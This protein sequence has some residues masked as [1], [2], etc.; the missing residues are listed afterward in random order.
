[1]SAAPVRTR[2]PALVGALI[3]VAVLL[4][5]LQ[6]ATDPACCR[7]RSWDDPDRIA[8]SVKI[9]D[10]AIVIHT[11]SKDGTDPETIEIV[12]EDRDRETIIRDKTC[13]LKSDRGVRTR[14]SWDLSDLDELDCVDIDDCDGDAI[15][16]LGE[17]IHIGRGEKVGG[18][19][20]AIGGSVYVEGDVDG[21]V[22]SLG[23]SVTM[24]SSARVDGD[25]VAVAGDL[26]LQD[27]CQ[28][29]GDAV[30]VGGVIEDDGAYVGGD[31]VVIDF[32]LW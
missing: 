7:E 25:V 26:I 8:T 5:A 23:G 1:M 24:D 14:I 18:D 4:L 31:T 11:E 17:D 19:V 21:D 28:V 9:D 10:D 27:G 2:T 13:K 30:S 6:A 32:D 12:P 22:V 16:Q 3:A 29:D 15:I 20:V